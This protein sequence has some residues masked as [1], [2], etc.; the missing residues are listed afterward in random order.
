VV[1]MGRKYCFHEKKEGKT[2][3]IKVRVNMEK[4]F[5]L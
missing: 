1:G 4:G 3:K 5:I 2:I